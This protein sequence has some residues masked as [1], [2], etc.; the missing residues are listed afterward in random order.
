M[1]YS[2]SLSFYL[3]SF[4]WFQMPFR[5]PYYIYSSC[6]LGLFLAV[7]VSQTFLVLD[8]LDRREG[9]RSAI[10][11]MTPYWDFSDVF[12]I[13]GWGYGFSRGLLQTVPLST[14]LIRGTGDKLDF[15]LLILTL[16]TR[17]RQFL[18]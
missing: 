6:L 15:P 2:N 17:S 8:D 7:T 5:T 1:L 16:I 4:F 9:Y 11:Q 18:F 12:P 14:H 10:L 3:M 13:L